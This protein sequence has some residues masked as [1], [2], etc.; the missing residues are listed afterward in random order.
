M[1]TLPKKFRPAKTIAQKKRAVNTRPFGREPWIVPENDC[2]RTVFR[3][4]V[5]GVNDLSGS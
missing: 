4:Q 3:F 5:S 1:P 2:L